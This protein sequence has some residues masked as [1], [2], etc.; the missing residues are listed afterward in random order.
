M[1]YDS[2]SDKGGMTVTLHWRRNTVGR[3]ADHF[4]SYERATRRAQDHECARTG[5]T[6][7]TFKYPE[8]RQKEIECV[9][10]AP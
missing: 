7:I 6:W 5:I 1:A 8:K 10:V 3:K 9:W 2:N 4:R